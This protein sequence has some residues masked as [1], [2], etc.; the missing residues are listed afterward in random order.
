LTPVN[1]RR[2]AIAIFDFIEVFYNT[3]RRH[4]AIGLISPAEYERRIGQAA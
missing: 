2:E 4:A 1:V 3:H